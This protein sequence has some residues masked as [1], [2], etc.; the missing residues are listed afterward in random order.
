MPTWGAVLE[1]LTKA[2]FMMKFCLMCLSISST[3]WHQTGWEPLGSAIKW[4]IIIR[5]MF[6]ELQFG[7]NVAP[8][9]GFTLRPFFSLCH[10]FGANLYLHCQGQSVHLL[11]FWGRGSFKK[12]A[13]FHTSPSLI[14]ARDSFIPFMKWSV[15]NSHK[16]CHVSLQLLW[17]SKRLLVFIVL[18]YQSLLQD[19]Q[20]KPKL[21]YVTK[22]VE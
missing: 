9:D 15:G 8:E 13:G 21:T 19:L 17:P 4:A 14:L 7:V 1:P 22:T 2:S 6:C 12:L 11:F 16:V 18:K 5:A 10:L 20:K 3:L